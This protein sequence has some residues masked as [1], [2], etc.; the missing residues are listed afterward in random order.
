MSWWRQREPAE[1]E[2]AGGGRE[3]RRRQRE[4]AEA[5]SAGGGRERRRRERVL[6]D[7]GCERL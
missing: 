4:P 7:R 2:R 6:G 3:S 1:A 5:E